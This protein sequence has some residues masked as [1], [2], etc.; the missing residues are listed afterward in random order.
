M[1]RGKPVWTL[2][3]NWKYH[4]TAA[5]LVDETGRVVAFAEEERFSRTKRAPKSYP[6]R[7][8]QDCL[9]EKAT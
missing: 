7:A 4:D 3:I 2:G 6:V 1:T 5:A 8:T 9:A